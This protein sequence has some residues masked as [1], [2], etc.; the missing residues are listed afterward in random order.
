MQEHDDLNLYMHMSFT[1]CP[2][3]GKHNTPIQPFLMN[4]STLPLCMYIRSLPAASIHSSFILSKS[5]FSYH[6]R[7]LTASHTA[8]AYS[9]L[10][11][12]RMRNLRSYTTTPLTATLLCISS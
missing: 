8:F 4:S 3:G 6:T 1:L 9:T 10:D 11:D 2:L 7:V 5:L 12:V